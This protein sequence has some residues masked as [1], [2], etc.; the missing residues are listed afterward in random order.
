MPDRLTNTANEYRKELRQAEGR[1]AG[2]LIEA[3]NLIWQQIQG[4]IRT[5]TRQIRQA[6][7]DG[8]IVTNAWLNRRTR[9]QAL[10]AQILVL[11]RRF[12]RQAQN[13]VISSQTEA[14]EIS[15]AQLTKSLGQAGIRS[16]FWIYPDEAVRNLISFLADGSPV[17]QVIALAE[18][19]TGSKI[20]DTLIKGV[21][22]GWNPRRMERE[23]RKVAGQV[24]SHVLR[25][26]RTEALRAFRETNYQTRQTNSEFFRGWVWLS[27]ANLRTCASCW[28]MHGSKHKSD[29][30]MDEHPNGSCV[31][32]NLIVGFPDPEIPTGEQLFKKLSRAEQGKIL[33]PGKLEAFR[34]G[35]ITLSDLVHVSKSRAWGSTRREAS[36]TQA[37][38]NK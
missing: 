32:R 26:H 30:R 19:E 10:E 18:L 34:D 27:A 22:L 28:A 3:Y 4:D 13:A 9:L 33:S 35:K 23:A 2:Q 1:A 20:R 6:Q 14:A 29:E 38:A 31:E 12:E 15:R 5:I 37:L 8:A 17:A 16:S 7:R 24:L 21:A 25:I 36:L 11:M